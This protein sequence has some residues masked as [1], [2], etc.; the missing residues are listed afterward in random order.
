MNILKFY[1]KPSF[2][3][4]LIKPKLPGLKIKFREEYLSINGYRHDYTN[5]SKVAVKATNDNF[6]ATPY[7]F[8]KEEDAKIVDYIGLYTIGIIELL[9]LSNCD[10]PNSTLGLLKVLGSG[11]DNV[12]KNNDDVETLFE[13]LDKV[14]TTTTE[15]TEPLSL[16][17][18]MRTDYNRLGRQG[19][20]SFI[21]VLTIIWLHNKKLYWQ[22]FFD[23]LDFC[24][25]IMLTL[26]D[27]YVIMPKN[28]IKASQPWL[29]KD[30]DLR[31]QAIEY[32]LPSTEKIRKI[33]DCRGL[34]IMMVLNLY[35]RLVY[36]YGYNQES[37][38]LID[39]HDERIIIDID[40]RIN[41][42]I[43]NDDQ[44]RALKGIGL[45]NTIKFN[46]FN[47]IDYSKTNT[48][49]FVL[50]NYKMTRGYYEE[51]LL[52]YPN[53]PEIS[54][55]AD[56]NI[57]YSN[58]YNLFRAIGQLWFGSITDNIDKNQDKLE[59]LNKEISKLNNEI[60]RYRGMVKETEERYK[61]KEN[62]E[63]E[64]LKA[65]LA[66][67]NELINSKN[68]TIDDLVNK[69]KELNK[70]LSD[71]YDDDFEI[72][73]DELQV[74][75]EEMVLFLNEFKIVLIGGRWELPAK[76]N[77][78]GW[79]NISQ[80]DKDNLCTGV[81]VAKYADFTVINTRFVSHTI[82]HKV[83]SVTDSDTRMSYNGTNPEKLIV[84]MYDFVKKFI[85]D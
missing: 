30:K 25:P 14:G 42:C 4:Q 20:I 16:Y 3:E 55:I 51:Y 73:E 48:C 46:V 53:D 66:K 56:V 24:S 44:F 81:D 79:T 72:E 38:P 19:L 74:P 47:I 35:Y 65:E 28:M 6:R 75:I 45:D 77:E 17:F 26:F 34:S 43:G 33:T 5:L 1:D 2:E 15:Y 22:L 82:V 23:I 8:S 18:M 62:E 41:N 64:Q 68:E 83:E 85:G 21:D 10:D 69:N 52:Q 32:S 7:I 61:N 57:H 78:Y 58:I 84:A 12:F 67:A 27:D 54:H 36:N 39:H 80:L 63:I 59:K 49:T 9:F 29:N 31:F 71:I 13:L 60:D 40:K 76:L 50:H 37:N 70:T 11:T